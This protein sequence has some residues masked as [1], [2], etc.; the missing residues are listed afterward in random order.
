MRKTLI[1]KQPAAATVAPFEITKESVPYTLQIDGDLAAN[2]I[3]VYAIGINGSDTTVATDEN[4]DAI[5]FSTSKI[6]HTFHGPAY[7]SVVK[8]VTAN[9]VG[10]QG[11]S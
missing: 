4:G 6:W 8:G 1:P 11:I 10:L 3:P 2:T 5:V 9:A 7:I